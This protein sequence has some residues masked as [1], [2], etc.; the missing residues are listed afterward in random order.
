MAPSLVL[1][2]EGTLMLI[3]LAWSQSSTEL[4]DAVVYAYTTQATYPL[5][6]TGIRILL[7]VDCVY[8]ENCVF[9]TRYLKRWALQAGQRYNFLLE[10]L[11][12]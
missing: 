11:A 10:L 6:H 9:P 8:I 5:V 3:P 4:S 2:L 12:C 1:E 7:P